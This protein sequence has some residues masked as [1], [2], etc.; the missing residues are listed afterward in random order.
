NTGDPRAQPTPVARTARCEPDSSGQIRSP[1]V[2]PATRQHASTPSRSSP[3]PRRVESALPD[4]PGW[5]CR[6]DRMFLAQRLRFARSAP[7]RVSYPRE[8]QKILGEETRAPRLQIRRWSNASFP[9]WSRAL[10]Q[11]AA[12]TRARRVLQ[13]IA[14]LCTLFLMTG[15]SSD[16]AVHHRI[17]ATIRPKGNDRSREH[18]A[19]EW[20]CGACTR[21]K[22]LHGRRASHG[23][24]HFSDR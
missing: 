6:K 2:Y 10:A 11:Q 24:V 16:P 22:N 23:S 8:Q 19:S 21:S 1:S 13:A 5:F 4:L 20:E 17:Q 14:P 12:L 7:R 15:E 3:S 9:K 18:R